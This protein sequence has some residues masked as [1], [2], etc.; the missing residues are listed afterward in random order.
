MR[1]KKV[2]ID[3]FYNGS[4]SSVVFQEEY[5]IN[6]RYVIY[7]SHDHDD[8]HIASMMRYDDN[9]VCLRAA[10]GPEDCVCR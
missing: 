3:L 5:F 8:H 1:K 9:K 2:V 10:Q 6:T 7:I 4:T